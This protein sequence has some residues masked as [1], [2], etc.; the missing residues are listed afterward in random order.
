MA[1]LADCVEVQVTAYLEH[2]TSGL[3]A[4]A[5]PALDAIVAKVTLTDCL[6]C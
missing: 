1:V 3:E 2:L 6:A 4:A 5:H